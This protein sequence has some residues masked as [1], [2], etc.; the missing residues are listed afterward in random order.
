MHGD[1]GILGCE[2]GTDPNAIRT[3]I[4]VDG[5]TYIVPVQV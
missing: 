5:R 1:R 2:S 3:T 4:E